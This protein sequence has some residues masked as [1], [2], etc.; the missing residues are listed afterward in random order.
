MYMAEC[1]QQLTR[2][3]NY[4]IPALK[5]QI[6]R[7]QQTQR[8]G[9]SLLFSLLVCYDYYIHSIAL[10]LECLLVDL[11]RLSL[12]DYHK[13]SYH[14]QMWSN[15]YKYCVAGLEKLPRGIS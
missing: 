14:I 2:N 12:Y 15:L 7:C 5:Q 13:Q 3:V 9:T 10:A 8:V 11:S 6:S 4:E 1:A